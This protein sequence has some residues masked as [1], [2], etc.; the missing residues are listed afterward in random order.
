[1]RVRRRAGKLTSAVQPR[2]SN[3][4][5]LE[6]LGTGGAGEVQTV[7]TGR[8]LAPRIIVVAA[9]ATGHHRPLRLSWARLLRRVSELDLEHCLNCGGELKIIAVILEQRVIEKPTPPGVA[10]QTLRRLLQGPV[11]GRAGPWST[12]VHSSQ[13]ASISSTAI[14][15]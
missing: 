14:A 8:F 5:Y 6:A 2:C 3:G 12:S 15:A 11:A 10:R 4:S 1:V 9:E 13:T 7:T